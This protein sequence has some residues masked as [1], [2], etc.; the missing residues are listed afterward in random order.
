MCRYRY[1]LKVSDTDTVSNTKGLHIFHFFDTK[2]SKKIHRVFWLDAVYWKFFPLF[3]VTKTLLKIHRVLC[4]DTVYWKFF[5][6]FCHKK[7]IDGSQSKSLDTVYWGFFPLF[8]SQ[9]VKEGSQNSMVS[10]FRYFGD[11]FKI[12]KTVNSKLIY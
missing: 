8:L 5:P 2:M 4:L 6:L 7:F 10:Q 11:Y 1:I 3:F 9:K 12:E